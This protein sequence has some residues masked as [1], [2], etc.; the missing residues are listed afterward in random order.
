MKKI[1]VTLSNDAEKYLNELMYSLTGKDDKAATQSECINESLETL[2]MF[3]SL[4]D[5]QLRNWNTDFVKN[6]GD[7]MHRLADPLKKRFDKPTDAQIVKMAI[8]FNDGV[9]DQ[10]KLVDMVACVEMIVNRLYENGVIDSPVKS[11]D[12]A[13]SVLFNRDIMEEMMDSV[14]KEM[15]EEERERKVLKA[16][17]WFDM[18]FKKA[19]T[20]SPSTEKKINKEQ[21]LDYVKNH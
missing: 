17:K 4:T 2:A 19:G 9:W 1:T 16:D 11:E 13:E 6:T 8:L 12:H 21:F 18:I 14:M 5:N 10:D 7:Y 15:E 3:E 20:Y